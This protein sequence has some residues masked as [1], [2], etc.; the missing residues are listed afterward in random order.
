MPYRALTRLTGAMLAA[1]PVRRRTEL[2]ARLGHV[3]PGLPRGG[4]WLHGASVGEIASA[5][6][7]VVALG[8]AL[9]IV[10]TANTRTG[11]AAAETQGLAASLAPLDLP[12]AL[13]RFLDALAPRIAVGIESELWPNRSAALAARGIPQVL[14]G[15]RL[16]ARSAARWARRPGLIRP[17]LARLAA[18]S[19]QD[20]DSEARLVALGL[21]EARLLGRVNLKLAAALARPV[22]PHPPTRPATLL[23]ASTHAGEE[24]AVLDA[25]A[26]LARGGTMPR[27]ILAPRHPERFDEVFAMM[28]A[29]GLAPA[30]RSAGAGAGAP[31][32]LADSMGEMDLWY[33]AAGICFTGGSLVPLGGHTPWEP[34]AQACA[35]LHGPHVANFAGD[36]ADLQAAGAAQPVSAAELAPA[37]ATLLREPGRQAAMGAAARRVLE[38]KAGDSGPLARTILQI[39][40]ESALPGHAG[41]MI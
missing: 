35:L 24:E 21:P 10:A 28:A 41:G 33:A 16:S 23:A 5:A 18:V 27:L 7:L 20:A 12:Q 31:V 15:A 32:L 39:A 9:P 34:A 37:V 38:A 17:M 11:R 6:G 1:L 36:Y 13:A 3:P 25:V 4:I 14:V 19:A 29:R 26:A 22:R 40:E 8:G 30:R 2:A